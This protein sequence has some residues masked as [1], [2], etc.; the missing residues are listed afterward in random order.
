MKSVYRA[1]KVMIALVFAVGFLV[2]PI[3]NTAD[4]SSQVQN[5]FLTGEDVTLTPSTN[6]FDYYLKVPERLEV[7]QAEFQVY[8]RYST[9][10]MP[11][12]SLTLF[13]DGRPYGSVRLTD[14][15]NG[16]GQF[17]AVIPAKDL[18]PGYHQFSVRVL[19]V[20]TMDLC[21][22]NEDPA[23]WLV[24]DK[25]SFIHM[26][27][28]PKQVNVPLKYFPEPFVQS[29]LAPAW[30]VD[31][32]VPDQAT[33]GELRAASKVIAVLSKH[34]PADYREATLLA[35]SDWKK[36]S[37]NRHV[38]V[39]GKSSSYPGEWKE[40]LGSLQKQYKGKGV[41]HQMT[42]TEAEDSMDRTYLFVMGEND[43]LVEQA[44]QALHYPLLVQQM[45]G[46]TEAVSAEMLTQASNMQKM[47]PTF[48]QKAE[49]GKVTLKDLSYNQVSLSN[50]TS[51]SI[52]Y[53]FN[54]PHDWSYR[55]GAGLRLFYQHGK[56]E[57]KDRGSMTVVVN[58]TPVT[59]VPLIG[60][61][62]ARQELFV[63]FPSTLRIG[64]PITITVQANQGER[65]CILGVN[66]VDKYITIL[67]DSQLVL[68][69]DVSKTAAL[70]SFPNMFVQGENEVGATAVL[71]DK[72]DKTELT[73]FAQLV[74]A[75][76]K[77]AQRV[78]ID[79]R[80]DH[81]NVAEMDDKLWVFD[82]GSQSKL[83]QNWATEQ[84]MPVYMSK[85]GLVSNDIPLSDEMKASGAFIQQR[86]M[87]NGQAVLM[88][89]AGN[90]ELM[91][92]A[93]ETML[94]PKKVTPDNSV[95]AILLSAQLDTIE[96]PF[97]SKP[98]VSFVEEMKSR[99]TDAVQ[100]IDSYNG[101]MVIAV[102]VFGL[103]VLIVL[104]LLIRFWRKKNHLDQA[105]QQQQNQEDT[106]NLSRT[107]RHH[108]R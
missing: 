84:K 67:P 49:K 64:E 78:D 35:Y 48:L 16:R 19:T 99:T 62:G 4:A 26:K 50:F 77:H 79:V 39:V 100:H 58:G 60:E 42:V 21:L 87:K 107:E 54:T 5:T 29:T 51:E 69:H 38:I 2:M 74:A 14:E 27:Y 105:E 36:L 98:P 93:V 32:V 92:S 89:S 53:V 59:S 80:R 6:Q 91:Q 3:A 23:N 88:V 25:S 71:S 11:E 52:T 34:A 24:L 37:S 15:G 10:L 20:S 8:Y 57:E 7:Q 9:E 95:E 40:N 83:V 13:M 104:I 101:R 96:L 90:S 85:D 65:E 73:A 72:P 63:P 76:S 86:F 47:K 61:G 17:K 94:N 44:A 22:N 45:S 102:S 1:L 108:K 56:L 18:T 75:A 28:Q 106:K 46:H 33:D 43:Q 97:T 82:L 41:L 55:K 103:T 66:G 12:S 31:V 30:Q 70:A 68:P 81:M